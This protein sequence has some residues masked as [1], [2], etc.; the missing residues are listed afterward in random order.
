MTSDSKKFYT[1]I[2]YNSVLFAQSAQRLIKVIAA[3]DKKNKKKTWSV[4]FHMGYTTSFTD[5]AKVIDDKSKGNVDIESLI[6]QKDY[7]EPQRAE[8]LQ[9]WDEF[10]SNHREAIDTVLTIRS[11]ITAHFNKDI[12]SA[13]DAKQ[14]VHN[15]E[16]IQILTEALLVFIEKLPWFEKAML[17]TAPQYT[18]FSNELNFDFSDEHK[19][20][21]D[22]MFQ[23]LLDQLNQQE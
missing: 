9:E 5:L 11:N 10:K 15:T 2:I 22:K 19:R 20:A 4:L 16:P 8:L 17:D 18:D 7:P 12:T 6:S 13:D 3:S 23:D 21:V 1:E 14:F